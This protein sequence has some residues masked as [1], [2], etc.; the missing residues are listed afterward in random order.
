MNETPAA[1][2]WRNR[3]S[4]R[5]HAIEFPGKGT[6]VVTFEMFS[7]GHL[8][9]GEHRFLAEI[10]HRSLCRRNVDAGLRSSWNLRSGSADRALAGFG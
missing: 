9:E 6:A 5:L 8:F 7:T 3:I 4:P 10:S 2:G 1:L